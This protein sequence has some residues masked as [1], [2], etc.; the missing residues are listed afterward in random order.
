MWNLS[1]DGVLQQ[2]EH[3]PSVST[4]REYT[5]D[6]RKP[7]RSGKKEINTITYLNKITFLEA[8]KLRVYSKATKA[9]T[10]SRQSSCL[11]RGTVSENHKTFSSL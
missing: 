9:N 8:R 1:L 10:E 4:T 3:S 7:V 11:S 5:Q 2:L 6:T